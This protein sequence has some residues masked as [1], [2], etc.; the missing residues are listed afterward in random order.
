MLISST[1]SGC[2]A[3]GSLFSEEAAEN[4]GSKQNLCTL[5][6]GLS[7][8]HVKIFFFLGFSGVV[9]SQQPQPQPHQPVSGPHNH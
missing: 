2:S 1:R 4:R 9:L 8:L 6:V 3:P 7:F 5:L